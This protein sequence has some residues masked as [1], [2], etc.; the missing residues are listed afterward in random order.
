MSVER[1]HNFAAVELSYV[2]VVDVIASVLL[3]VT[4]P[5]VFIAAVAIKN[6]QP[7]SSV[8]WRTLHRT[9]QTPVPHAPI[10]ND[11]L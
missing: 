10:P 8:R 3:A 2:R 1:E 6:G 7:W 9:Q 5:L 11:D 4:L